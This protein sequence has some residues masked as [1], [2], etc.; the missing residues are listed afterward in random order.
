MMPNQRAKPTLRRR[1]LGRMLERCREDAG[2]TQQAAAASM[3]WPHHKLS[4]IENA[5][6]HIP[7]KDVE[8]YLRKCGVT[9]E[10]FILALA[11][12][13]KNAAKKGW[14][15]GFGDAILTTY[16]D[17]ISVETE[18]TRIRYYAPNLIPGLLQPRNYAREIIRATGTLVP[19]LVEA[20]VDVRTA[21]QAVLTKAERPLDFWTVI[22]ESVL[23]HEFRE[24]PEAMYEQLERLLELSQR[25]TI[26]IQ[27]MPI[28]AASHPGLLG[29]FSLLDFEKPYPS[30]VQVEDI[31]GSSF[32]EEDSDVQAFENAW[33]RIIAAALPE[34]RS[35]EL[36]KKVMEERRS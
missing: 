16:M 30:I 17:H 5:R 18:A 33:E 8:P 26:T 19:E 34:D 21:R 28:R 9:D 10:A 23:H 20:R 13:A 3:N 27:V 2:L 29:L 11:N 36:I 4:K 35:R 12:L 24:N 1:Q 7:A 6:A 32:I 25:P 15:A 31:R 22:N 14:W